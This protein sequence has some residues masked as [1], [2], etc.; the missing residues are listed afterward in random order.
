[1]MALS[2]LEVLKVKGCPVVTWYESRMILF[3]SRLSCAWPAHTYRDEAEDY[4]SPHRGFFADQ[5]VGLCCAFSTNRLPEA[6]DHRR[7]KL[8][9]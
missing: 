5:L 8:H 3:S 2:R 1:M 6:D 7:V 9:T 4:S